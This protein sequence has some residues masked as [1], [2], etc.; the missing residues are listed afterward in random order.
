MKNYANF[1]QS[2]FLHEKGITFREPQFGDVHW[3]VHP[4][5]ENNMLSK[6][7]GFSPYPFGVGLFLFECAV[8][9][10]HVLGICW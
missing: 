10:Y 3:T 8:L 9:K 6:L 1:E 4:D 7:Y 2:K 5:T